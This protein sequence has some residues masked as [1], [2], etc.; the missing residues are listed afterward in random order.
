[1]R[2]H[3]SRILGAAAVL[4]GCAAL[5]GA[6][7]ATIVVGPGCSLQEAIQS[8]NFDNNI[9]IVSTNPDHFMATGCQPGSGD[10]TI[11]LP[12][13]A[14]IQFGGPA[15]D[16]HNPM[17]PTA[18]PIVFT[19]IV[20]EGHG[21]RLEPSAGGSM[22][23]FAVGYAAIDTNPGPGN[24]PNVKSGTGALTIRDVHLRGFGMKGGDGRDG[25][26][27]GLGAGGAIYVRDATLVVDSCTF[28]LNHAQGGDG[29]SGVSGGG[30]GL[31]GNG[32]HRGGGATYFGGGG[33]GGS[34]GDGG[35][36]GVFVDNGGSGIEGRGGGGGGSFDGGGVGIHGFDCGGEGGQTGTLNGGD[37]GENAGCDGGGGGGGGSRRVGFPSSG[38]GANGAYGAGGGGGGYSG[39]DGGNGG[40]GGGGGGG[41]DD[42]GLFGPNGGDAGFGG[43]SGAALGGVTHVGGPGTPGHYGGAADTTHGGAGAGLGGA[44]FGDG[45]SI[46]IFD[47]TFTGKSVAHG[48]SL[49]PHPAQDAGGAIFARNG[50]LTV[51]DSTIAGNQATGHGG[52]IVVDL[53]DGGPASL[54][55]YNTIVSGNGAAECSVEG[56]SGT[57]VVGA[58]NLVLDNNGC[59]NVVVTD[60]PQLGPLQLNAPGVTPTMA[61]AAGSPAAGAADGPTS[62]DVDQRGV[63]RPQG[64]GADIGAFEACGTLTCPGNITQANDHG[65]C[66]AT[67]SYTP[68]VEGTCTPVCTP[69]S[70]SF[71]PV[72]ATT[73]T[74]TL[75]SQSCSFTVTV[76]DT[77]PPSI[78]GLMA[79]PAVLWPPNHAMTEETIAYA[80]G[81][82]CPGSSC[83]LTVMSSEPILG[84]GDGDTAPDWVVEDPHHEQLRAER[85]GNGPG[86]TYTSTVSCTDAHGLR[87][88]KSTTTFVPHAKKNSESVTP[89]GNK[90]A[91][92]ESNAPKVTEGGAGLGVKPAIDVST[93]KSPRHRRSSGH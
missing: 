72:G 48:I 60:D 38:N 28:E 74:C 63:S 83:R 85:A 82:N 58:G 93:K 90:S 2:H 80:G 36:G 35:P 3:L 66:G 1:M 43:G 17:G 27:G 31:W 41:C 68:T 78:D 69:A 84:T 47:S 89:Q 20:I 9:A 86:R 51:S 11:V 87:T 42:Q 37:D 73:V 49:S 34:R 8:A 65:S 53:D 79:M 25:G 23:A 18:T 22:R 13:G 29:S 30:G 45:A 12:D 40:F 76:N 88:E 91:T 57:T 77:E 59:P 67:V 52:G 44:I 33:G 15:I 26:G 92:L 19:N 14:L 46:Q 10:D 75:E 54:T 50:S 32:G 16:A 7:G 70:G 4:A 64:T 81:D 39:G 24:N 71:F 55:L 6:Q 61:I 21:A 56:D 62:L 5:P